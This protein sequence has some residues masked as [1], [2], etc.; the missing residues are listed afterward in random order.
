MVLFLLQCLSVSAY[1]DS[2][3][4]SMTVV[5]SPSITRLMHVTGS[6]DNTVRIWRA[7][8][9]CLQTI[10]HPGNIWAVEFLPNQDVVTACSDAVARIWSAAPERQVG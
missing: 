5:P 7:S 1:V 9:E 10:E 6:E 8:G 4:P 3:V 2:P